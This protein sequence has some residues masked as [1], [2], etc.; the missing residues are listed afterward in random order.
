M[1]IRGPQIL[2]FLPG[3]Q[4][5][6]I[7]EPEFLHKLP[8]CPNSQSNGCCSSL[9]LCHHSCLIVQGSPF[10]CSERPTDADL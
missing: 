7:I 5:Q 9:G 1:M 4:G 2:N 8:R 10:Q 6:E 3:S